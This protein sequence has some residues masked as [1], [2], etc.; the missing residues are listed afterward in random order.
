MHAIID[1]F[2][3][4]FFA[5]VLSSPAGLPYLCTNPALLT[6]NNDSPSGTGVQYGTQD[7]VFSIVGGGTA[8]F[9]VESANYTAFDSNWSETNDANGKPVKQKG[10]Q[11]VPELE[12]NLHYIG[13]GTLKRPLGFSE[14]D[15]LSSSGAFHRMVVS[16]IIENSTSDG[17]ANKCVIGARYK[18]N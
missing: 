2:L 5:G 11:K 15:F 8:T 9:T 16:R 17:E 1:L 7:V 14:F 13:G 3:L 4:L 6:Y 10:Q 12:L 18:L